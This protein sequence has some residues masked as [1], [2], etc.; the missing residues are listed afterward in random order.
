[1]K[2]WYFSCVFVPNSFLFKYQFNSE[3]R[4]LPLLVHLLLFSNFI[5]PSLER[6]IPYS[7]PSQICLV[8]KLTS[9]KVILI[10]DLGSLS[11]DSYGIF[12][13]DKHFVKFL[14]VL[15]YGF[16]N[17]CLEKNW[18]WSHMIKRLFFLLSSIKCYLN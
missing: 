4:D 1:M 8:Y 17:Q 15:C 11:R 14:Y 6:G 7:S 12:L 16:L 9:R 5:L 13:T 18:Y 3:L 10:T 2:I